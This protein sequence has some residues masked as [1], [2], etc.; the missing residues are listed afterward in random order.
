MGASLGGGAYSKSMPDGDT[1]LG[2]VFT[3]SARDCDQICNCLTRVV[4]RVGT[5]AM[6]RIALLAVLV[7]VGVGA[8]DF[9]REQV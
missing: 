3:K 6:C 9:I 5:L 7:C 4:S 1:F 8:Q 2:Q